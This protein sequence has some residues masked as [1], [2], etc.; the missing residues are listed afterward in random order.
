LQLSPKYFCNYFSNYFS[1]YFLCLKISSDS[2]NE[3]LKKRATK[4]KKKRKKKR[5]NRSIGSSDSD[6]CTEP[7]PP[8]RRKVSPTVD[9]VTSTKRSAK[10]LREKQDIQYSMPES[11]ANPP[12]RSKINPFEEEEEKEDEEEDDED[13]E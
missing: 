11:D 4:R 9:M 12:R 6:S 2:D 10:R 3:S 13:M 5:S 8:K 7:R 1:N